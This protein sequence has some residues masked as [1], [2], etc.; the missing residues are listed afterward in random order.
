MMGQKGGSKGDKQNRKPRKKS[1][2]AAGTAS[3]SSSSSTASA[4]PRV[5]NQINVPIRRQIR[6]GKIN[7]KLREAAESGQSFR[8]TKKGN[9]VATTGPGSVGPTRKTSYRKT[10]D[11][12]TIQQKAL[13][14]QRK[15]QNPDWSVVLNQTKADPLVLVDGYNVIY[16]WARLKKHM[17]RGDTERARQLL[18]DDLEG[19]ASLQRWRIECVFDGAGRAGIPGP[20]GSSTGAGS[21]PNG[22]GKDPSLSPFGN[23]GTV[24]TVYTGRGTEADA[25]IEGRCMAAKNT[26]LGLT[27]SSLIVATDDSQIKLVANSAGALCMSSDRFVL[28]LKS[29]KKSMQYRVEKAMADI[30]STPIRPESQWGPRGTAT[31]GTRSNEKGR[32]STK[33]NT[34]VSATATER[35]FQG[36]SNAE[37]YRNKPRREILEEHEDGSRLIKARYGANE[38][39][40]KDNRNKKKRMAPSPLAPGTQKKKKKK[41]KKKK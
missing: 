10:L 3:S 7:K 38:V 36:G 21:N 37:D 15:G 8:Q 19:L 34:T 23:T 24:R 40:I 26:T 28:E 29:V 4:L 17:V 18:L 25:Y 14:R 20:L 22:I 41:K 12:A 30:N 13:E 35:F 11:E 6:Y 39:I 1:S 5:S 16:K 2:Q 31:T 33:N 32:G 9:F 27:T